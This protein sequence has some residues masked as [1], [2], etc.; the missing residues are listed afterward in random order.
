[1]ADAISYTEDFNFPYPLGSDDISKGA[2][3]VQALAERVEEV[4][5]DAGIEIGTYDVLKTSTVFAGAIQGTYN[6][7]TLNTAIPLPNGT[8]ATTQAQSDGSTKVAT[9]AYVDAY[10]AGTVPDGS[11]G[12]AELADGVVTDLKVNAAAAI[13]YSKLNL[14]TSIVNADISATAAI[15]DTKLATIS[16]ASKVS[17]TATTATDANTAS[18]IVARDASG[19]FTAGMIT[20]NVTGALTGNASTVTT[21]ANLTGDVTS[22]G[23]ATSIA[24]GVIVNADVNAS[25]AISYSKL[26]LATSI[27]NADVS[28]SAAIAYSKLALTGAI[29]DADL[30]G[31]IAPAKIT[32]TAVVTADSR[33]TDART[34][35]GGAG[36]VLSGTYPNPGFAVDMATQGELDTHAS[37]TTSVHGIADTSVLATATDVSTAVSNHS[38][39]TTS[40]HGITD[41]SALV[42][43]SDARLSD[44]RT[45]T[46]HAGTHVP[47]GTDVLDY[48][49]I[50]GY[51]TALP[52]WSATTHPAGV[53]WVVNTVGE[54]YSLY[55]SDGVSAWKQVGGG[56]ASVTASDTAPSS[57]T[58][59]ALWFDS[60]TGKTFIWY[61]DGSSNQWVEVGEASQLSIPTHG[62]SH[63]RGGSDVIDG[64]RVSI[65]FVPSRYTRN[66]AASGA[67]DVTDLAANLSGIDTS[68][69]SLWVPPTA[70]IAAPAQPINN[71][72]NTYIAYSSGA[73]WDTNT[74][75]SSGANTRLTINVAGIYIISAHIKFVN[76]T[77]GFRYAAIDKN[78]TLLNELVDI[79]TNTTGD[80]WEISVTNQFNFAVNDYIQ[81]RVYHTQGTVL[82]V[83]GNFAATWI[84]KTA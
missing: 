61:V 49:K 76:G 30:A 39:D 40:V 24:S 3:R 42:V 62:S 36:G 73:Q 38:S 28:A 59:G 13:S 26:N 53:L 20:A 10:V 48:T 64:D 17:N 44:A 58:S 2:A 68:L 46:T 7:L 55:R 50:V 69:N 65:D 83:S 15:V 8:T 31:S 5:N 52:T 80:P 77:S 19:N 32:G 41:T 43:T 78:G 51:G 1:M 29:L 25:A 16:T 79:N 60:T 11:I 47:G 84:G 18:A 74:M 12:T 54:P 21:N 23:N 27:V 9:T 22:V 63:V 14:G 82:N 6:A 34:P 35:T 72:T 56:G 4:L 66:A 57:P 81:I 45:P 75:F 67:G 37:D 33:L 70:K 71:G